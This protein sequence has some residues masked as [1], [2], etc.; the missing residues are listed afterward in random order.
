MG[1]LRL[2]TAMGLCAIA[3]VALIGPGSSAVGFVSGGLT[4]EVQVLSPATMHAKGA[5]IDVP[6]KVVCTGRSAWLYVEVTQRVGRGLAKGQAAKNIVCTGQVQGI[7]VTM[8][9]TGTA[10]KKGTA[11]A[12][13]EIFGCRSRVCGVEV[14]DTE[15]QIGKTGR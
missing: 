11:F 3:A 4:L 9:A 13:A 1:R 12:H 5:A 6:V 2:W 10:F 14:H 15:F 7:S 8:A